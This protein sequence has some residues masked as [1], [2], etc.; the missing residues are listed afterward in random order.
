MQPRHTQGPEAAV[1]KAPLIVHISKIFS[2]LPFSVLRIAEPYGECIF[3]LYK[4]KHK[5]IK[6]HLT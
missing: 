3:P 2:L 4:R 1:Q 6:G 5:L